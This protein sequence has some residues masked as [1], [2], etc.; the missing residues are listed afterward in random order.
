[1]VVTITRAN[2]AQRIRLG[3]TQAELDEAEELLTY[4]TEAVT[5]HAPDAPDVVHNEAVYRLAGYIYDRPF[6][7]VGTRFSNALHNSG[8][9]SA[10]LPYRV[11]RLGLSGDDDTSTAPATAAANAITGLSI[12]GGN[13]VLTFGDG[14]TV[15]VPLPPSIGGVSVSSVVFNAN[16]GA[17]DVT[18][19]DGNMVSIPLPQGGGNLQWPGL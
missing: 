7:S 5:H 19:S 3:R 1:M 4:A 2:L 12:V 15:D 10:L 8:A 9:A 16:T 11:H 14:S 18:Y 6:A 17:I 13:I